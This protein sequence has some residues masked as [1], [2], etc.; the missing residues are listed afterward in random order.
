MG[1]PARR[2]RPFLPA[3]SHRLLA[4]IRP[5]DPSL[6]PTETAGH[7]TTRQGHDHDGHAPRRVDEAREHCRHPAADLVQGARRGRAPRRA[8]PQGGYMRGDGDVFLKP[9]SRFYHYVFWV[10]GKRVRGSTKEVDEERAR[11]VLRKKIE[12]VKS[13]DAVPHEERLALRDIEKL[14]IANYQL[15][16]N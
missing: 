14:L 9:A 15:K 16:K 2:V 1:L 10:D 8:R 3:P 4:D 13:G 5:Y 11:R 7:E 12:N 6:M